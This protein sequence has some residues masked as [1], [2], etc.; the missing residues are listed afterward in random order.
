MWNFYQA[1]FESLQRIPK[2]SDYTEI[3]QNDLIQ[4]LYIIGKHFHILPFD[5]QLLSLTYPQL[6]TLLEV[7]N[8]QSKLKTGSSDKVEEYIDPDFDKEFQDILNTKIDKNDSLPF[9]ED[10]EWVDVPID[11]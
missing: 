4:V 2:I 9:T 1:F 3:A 10:T 6:F 8:Q 11:S 5:K 7:I